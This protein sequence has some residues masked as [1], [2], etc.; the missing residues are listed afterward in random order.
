MN[1]QISEQNLILGRFE[2]IKS[3]YAVFDLVGMV[4]ICILNKN[5]FVKNLGWLRTVFDL[6]SSNPY[7]N[8]YIK[9]KKKIVFIFLGLL[10][11]NICLFS[12]LKKKLT[13]EFK[14]LV[15]TGE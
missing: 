8:L 15:C 6:K 7:N 12:K 2:I 3:C 1:N 14:M 9:I 5:I 10:L 13:Y 4:A 11:K